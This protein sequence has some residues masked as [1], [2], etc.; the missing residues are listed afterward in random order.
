MSVPAH[1]SLTQTDSFRLR[2]QRAEATRALIMAGVMAALIVLVVVRRLEGGAAMQVGLVFWSSLGVLVIAAAA[3]LLA[4][5]AFRRANRA[6]RLLPDRIWLGLTVLELSA[7]L[8]VMA[9]LAWRGPQGPL[10]ALSAPA[11]LVLPLVLLLSVLHLRPG[12]TLLTGLAAALG[13][14]ALVIYAINVA[15]PP[16]AAVPQLMSY[17]AILALCGVAAALAARHLKGYVHEAADEASARMQSEQA[18]NQ[19]RRELTL[20]RDIQQGLIPAA[21]PDLPGYDIAGLNRPAD[22]TG[23]DYFD[24]QPLPDGRLAVVMA[25]V[26]G[27]GIGPAMVMA[28]CRAYARASTPLVPDSAELLRRLNTLV[29]DDVKGRRFITLAVA[30]LDPASARV[31]LSSAGHGPTLLYRSAD[32]SVSRFGGD[33]IPLGL[34]REESY[35]SAKR[36]DLARGDLLLMMTD[37]FFEWGRASD[38]EQFGIERVEDV[39]RRNAAGSAAQIVGAIDA[40]VRAFAHDSPQPDDMTAVVLK[41]L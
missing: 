18:L 29:H 20:A 37:G 5:R 15:R 3:E 11:V 8:G 34:F 24:W 33:G 6:G 28:V 38:G 12:A 7:P 13:H 31:E 1:P 21:P 9:L 25:D 10:G 27:H 22:L 23:G 35:E 2:V 14:L 26:T 4:L 30:L 32:G 40:A 41:R 36:L 19:V 16:A 17:P 39:L